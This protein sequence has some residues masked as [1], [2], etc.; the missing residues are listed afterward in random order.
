MLSRTVVLQQNFLQRVSEG[1]LINASFWL[2]IYASLPTIL[3]AALIVGIFSCF[4]PDLLGTITTSSSQKNPEWF[5][6]L[7]FNPI[8]ES[9]L[10]TIIVRTC[11]KMKF[12]FMSIIVGAAS[13]S[14]LHS[15]QNPYWG[16]TVFC[17]FLVHSFAF[18][19]LFSNNFKKGWAV[20]S[21]AHSM[22]NAWVLLILFSIDKIL[23]LRSGFLA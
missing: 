3:I 12:G 2:L 14:A 22:H 15:L 7:V 18:F 21:L 9:L 1:H 16:M 13:L 8:F 6:Y 10:L 23:V 19:Y 17:L 5:P 11:I 4:A 20:I